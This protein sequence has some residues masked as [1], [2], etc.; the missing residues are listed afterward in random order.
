MQI[1]PTE[2]QDFRPTAGLS[3]RNFKCIAQGGFGDG[4]NNFAH[5]MAWF[6]GKLYVGTT[7]QNL[8]M[9]RLQSAFETLPFYKWPVECPDTLDGLDRLDRSAQI[10]CYDPAVKRWE[11][12]FR[13]PQVQSSAG[14]TV[15]REIGYRAMAVFQ[16]E[17]EPEAR[18][19]YCRVGASSCSG[20][21]YFEEF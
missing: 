6:D 16:G 5:S 1:V 4:Y 18:A 12:V 8:C 7:R 19:L 21:Q 11:M 15:A 2:T 10:W 14:G 9:L 13:S 17:S 20:R 3:M